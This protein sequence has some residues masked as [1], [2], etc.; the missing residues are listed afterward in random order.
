[1]DSD[2][3]ASDANNEWLGD[4]AR[5]TRMKGFGELTWQPRRTSIIFAIP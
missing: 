5:K 1:M 4:W 2:V 3:A